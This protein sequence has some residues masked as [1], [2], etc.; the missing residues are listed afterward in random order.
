MSDKKSE[1]YVSKYLALKLIRESAY[2][3]E[4]NGKFLPQ[5]GTSIQFVDGAYTT[6]DKDEIE[7][8]D[9]HPNQGN[10]FIKVDKDAVKE[11]AD[12]VQTL[13]ERNAE[14]EAELAKREDGGKKVEKE[15][16]LT[17]PELK[18]IAQEKGIDITGLRKKEDIK[19]AIENAGEQAEF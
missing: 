15:E 5:K 8:L 13:E 3:K 7:F 19:N 11:R 12:Y 18:E 9:N 16:E 6:S 1:T 2:T 10:I 17:I 14:L 4:V